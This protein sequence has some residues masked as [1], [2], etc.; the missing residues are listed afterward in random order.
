MHACE[1]DEQTESG[2]AKGPPTPFLQKT[3]VLVSAEDTTNEAGEKLCRKNMGDDGM[4][5]ADAA[6]E[7]RKEGKEGE[8]AQ[9]EC[10]LGRRCP[11]LAQLDKKM[12]K[13]ES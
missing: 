2:K 12:K 9:Q 7:A 13:D 8:E 5:Q 6:R 11:G 10:S 3:A 4:L 1:C